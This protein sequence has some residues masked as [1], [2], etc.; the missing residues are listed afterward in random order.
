MVDGQA[1]ST[2][3]MLMLIQHFLPIGDA[4]GKISAQCQV[5]IF[6]FVSVLGPL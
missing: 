6:I 5:L 2:A 3:V 4:D 1:M